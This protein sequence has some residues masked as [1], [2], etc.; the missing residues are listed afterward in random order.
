MLTKTLLSTSILL[1]LSPAAFAEK[2]T[3]FDEVVVSATR[4]AQSL[5]N[6]AASVAV[7]SS[8]ELEATMVRDVADIFEYT[9]GVTTSGS[10]RQG[11]QTINIRGIEGNRIKI[12]VDGVTQSQAF[13]DG[14]PYSFISSSAISIEPD[15]LKSVEIVKGAASSLHGSDAIGGVVAFETKDPRDFLKG[16]ATTGGQ[17]K[18]SYAS[19]DKSFSE[20]VAIAH[21]S[22]DLETL[23][24]FTR[25]DGQEPKNFGDHKENYSISGQDSANNDLLLKLQYQL[26]EAHRIEFTGEMLRNQVDSD[27][28][29]SS[30]KNYTGRDITKQYRLG[31]KHIWF[32]DLPL[33][34]T[35]TSR[36]SWQ[37][38]EENGLTK[39]FQPASAGRP[40][41]QPAN[42]DNHQTK[43]YF[44]SDDKIEL[45]AQFDKLITLN[46]SEHNIMYGINLL[47][48]DISNINNEYNSDPATPNQVIVYTPDAEEQ[49]IGLFIQNEI[50][51]LNGNLIV[52]PGLRYDSFRTEPGDNAGKGLSKFND[53]AVTGRLGTLYR[54]DPNSAIFAQVSQGLRSPNFTELYYSFSNLAHG[55]VIEPN[56]NLKSEKSL[57]YELGYRHNN[58]FSATD[59]SL[60]Y[61]SYDDFIERVVTK[62]ESKI[63]YHSYI[64]LR[65][66]TIKGVELSNQLKLDELLNAPRGLTTRLAAN[67]TEGKDGDGRPL[68]SIN[69]W[70]VV[71][72]LNFDDP[73]STW[74]TSLK[75]NYTAGKSNRNI[76]NDKATGGT[77]NQVELSSST[78]FDITAY[79]K[80]IKDL[81]LT[82]GIFNIAD[83]EYY[84]WNDIRGKNILDND[85]SQSKRNFAITA[86]YE[87]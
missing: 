35:I 62:V 69:P 48:S 12:L 42:N 81:T 76:N 60:F 20:H 40:P 10:S 34:D 71:A 52:T 75:L 21:R 85:Y 8:K 70:N 84:R 19:E 49:K 45:E 11:M 67:Y 55:Y 41:Y 78:I 58:D 32:S 80:P 38:K 2:T 17:I 9:P 13:D 24:A 54:L 83:K 25:R 27:I 51:L 59:I 26:S 65:E 47:S 31:L 63:N 7:I 6:T 15:M 14:G 33:A 53:S 29:H 39:R 28:V 57:S 22:G 61:S 77:E 74:G 73:D 50:A 3:Q 5:D 44:Y 43:D 82:A 87:F 30:Y 72:A 4:T 86:K 79:Y 36:V 46:N 16:D 1:A 66:A 37:S 68:N 23:V 18:L 64:N 56:P